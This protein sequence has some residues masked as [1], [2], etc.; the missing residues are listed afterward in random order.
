[1][2][3]VANRISVAPGYE[4][5]FEQRFSE[6]ESNLRQAPGFIRNLVLRPVEGGVYVVMTFWQ[7][8]ASFESW[9]HS[10]AFRRS[11]ARPAQPEMYSAPN[12]LEIHEVV[13]LIEA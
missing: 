9:T 8:M 6:R 5:T 13:H 1:M 4:Q 7:D 3:V 12:V 2:I 11:H 10:A